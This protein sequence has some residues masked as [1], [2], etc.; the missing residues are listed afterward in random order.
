[1]RI[2]IAILIIISACTYSYGQDQFDITKYNA[3]KEK[4]LNVVINSV[5]FDSIY[6]NKKVYFVENELLSKGTPL[7]LKRNRCKVKILEKQE[8]VRKGKDYVGIA[9]FTMERINPRSVR[10]QLFAS[11][12]YTLNLRLEKDEEVWKITNHMIME[13]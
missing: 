2:L 7:K 10:V 1:M 5:Q 3:E 9:D 13:D 8:L 4:I 11:P 12:N 6:S